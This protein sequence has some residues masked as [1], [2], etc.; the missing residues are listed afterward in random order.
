MG[1]SISTHIDQFIHAFWLCSHQCCMSGAALW[2]VDCLFS[3]I[4]VAGSS[5]GRRRDVCCAGS[6]CICVAVQDQQSASWGAG[7][8]LPVD[9]LCAAQTGTAAPAGDAYIATGHQ[10]SLHPTL[11][12]CKYMGF[13][14]HAL[15]SSVPCSTYGSQRHRRHFCAV[16]VRHEGWPFRCVVL[17]VWS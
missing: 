15:L 5:A 16:A 13:C 7:W 2:C 3:R 12:P 10:H 11:H 4:P 17:C 9:W 8:T 6:G 1:C 14:W